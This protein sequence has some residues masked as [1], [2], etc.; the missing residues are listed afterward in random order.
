MWSGIHRKDHSQDQSQST[1]RPIVA[2]FLSWQDS[3]NELAPQYMQNLFKRNSDCTTCCLRNTNTDLR[4][5]MKT[6]ANGQKC[7]SFRGAKLWNS[8]SAESKKAS[9]LNSFK[10][11]VE[12]KR[13]GTTGA[14]FGC[15]WLV[16]WLRW[17]VSKPPVWLL[18]SLGWSVR[19]G[20]LGW[21]QRPVLCWGS[22][23]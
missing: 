12:R 6:T 8:L 11:S 15:P 16:G 10:K 9:S 5:P 22:W 1:S 18:V 14:G 2:E 19:W 4:L 17:L 23:T 21:H 20:C 7:F 3:L 13:Q